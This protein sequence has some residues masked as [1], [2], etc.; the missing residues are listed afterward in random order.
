MVGLDGATI[1]RDG[2]ISVSAA[3]A[4][5]CRRHAAKA[6]GEGAAVLAA[7][8]VEEFSRREKFIP[9]MISHNPTRLAHAMRCGRARVES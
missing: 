7:M 6:S 1:G 9:R 2:V 5:Y 4:R 8:V 3:K